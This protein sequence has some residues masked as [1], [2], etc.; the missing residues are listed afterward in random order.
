[1]ATVV[2]VYKK[3]KGNKRTHLLPEFDDFDFESKGFVKSKGFNEFG[4]VDDTF[5][6]NMS[7]MPAPRSPDF[8]L[9]D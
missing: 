2:V 8:Y 7:R 5:Y 3:A 1:M 6:T 9:T 4:S